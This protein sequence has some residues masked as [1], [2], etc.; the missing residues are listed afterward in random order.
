[1]R[2]S[3]REKLFLWG[4]AALLAVL[5]VFLLAVDPA[6]K[7]AGE[8]KRLIPQKE[9][10]LKQLRLLLK[11]L[12]LLKEAKAGLLQKIPAGERAMPPLSRL[13]G[14]IERSGLRPSVK[15]IKPSPSP[16]A[17]GMVVDVIMEKAELPYLTR[18]LYEAQSSPG[19]FRVARINLKPRYTTPKYLDVSLQ[20]IF[21]QG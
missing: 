20:M 12:E 6:L 1:M 11:E 5:L 21:H 3:G 14:W 18:F 9:Q 2:I 16:G 13:D 15:S 7:R 10:E 19:G 4:G 8:L 17:E